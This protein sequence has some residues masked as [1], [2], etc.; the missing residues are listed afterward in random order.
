[1]GTN[2]TTNNTMGAVAL[3]VSMDLSVLSMGTLDIKPI[4]T[5]I[6]KCYV[7]QDSYVRSEFPNMNYGQDG[8]LIA[9]QAT[10]GSNFR[11]YLRFDL[12]Q[13]KAK[14]DLNDVID[15]KLYMYSDSTPDSYPLSFYEVPDDNWYEN[16]INWL[17]APSVDTQTQLGTWAQTLER[18]YSSSSSLKSLVLKENIISMAFG[19]NQG[20]SSL[21]ASSRETLN[22]P[23]IGIEVIDRSAYA[24]SS[25]TYD[26]SLKFTPTIFANEY[27]P[28]DFNLISK[29]LVNDI[30][31]QL[32]VS[33]IPLAGN[34]TLSIAEY[35]FEVKVIQ[36]KFEDIPARLGVSVTP[37]TIAGILDT[38]E[39][40]IKFS[41]ALIVREFYPARLGVS[42]A[43]LESADILATEH[44]PFNF[45]PTVF[46]G[47][48]ITL[49]LGVAAPG[50]VGSSTLAVA[51]FPMQFNVI[52]LV[53]TLIPCQL[54]VSAPL[55]SL[56][57]I[58]STFEIPF[59]MYVPANYFIPLRI[60]V[61]AHEHYSIDME[62]VPVL[63]IPFELDVKSPYFPINFD[64]VQGGA[65]Y[66]P[67]TVIPLIRD[68]YLAPL[69]LQVRVP[70][71][72]AFIV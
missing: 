49:A 23:Y 22:P 54:G 66:I 43:L 46:K 12:T 25:G 59:N 67:F 63:M 57:S 61:R 28:M 44:I 72:Y 39:I 2:A 13:E 16:D 21:F 24:L 62:V 19:E 41:P 14:I 34:Y 35:P 33:T 18:A 15:A 6:I 17:N 55:N 32:G 71:T 60:D 64:V 11:T 9:G 10:Q 30:P 3:P 38:L 65:D 5:K 50:N 27:I 4:P 48:D 31:T 29:N 68:V 70:S 58:L 45:S 47:L 37:V 20:P 36:K 56:G 53:N 26:A 7:A 42:A 1:M 51:E 69:E 52:Q 8:Q 40:P